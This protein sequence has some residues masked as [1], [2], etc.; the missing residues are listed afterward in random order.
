MTDIIV[1]I[2]KR[3][4][5]AQGVNPLPAD[6]V[7]DSVVIQHKFMDA[8]ARLRRENIEQAEAI[9]MAANAMEIMAEELADLRASVKAS[10]VLSMEVGAKRLPSK[11]QQ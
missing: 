6:R 7:L 8:V 5:K 11:D 3:H 1:K 10:G 9:D 2:L 4:A